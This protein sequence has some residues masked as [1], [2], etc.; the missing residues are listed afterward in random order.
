MTNSGKKLTIPTIIT[1]GLATFSMYFGGSC[2]L[3]PVTWG[4][5]SGSS[6]LAAMPGIIITALLLPYAAYIAMVRGGDSFWG[7][8]SG[9]GRRFGAVFGIMIVAVLGPLYSIP[10][11]S[12]AAWES[13]CKV[14]NITTDSIIPV[15]LFQIVFYAIGYW[16]LFQPASLMDKL[17]KI[18]T[19]VLLITVIAVVVKGLTNPLSDWV[20]KMYTESA[21]EYGL[22]S[23][24][25]TT[26]LPASL[27]FGIVI[28][29]NLKAKGV[30]KK[31]MMKPIVVIAG[32]G[33]ALLACTHLSQ[34]LLGA[35]TGDL[36][37]DYSYATLYA[38][39]ILAM[40]GKVGGIFF[41]IALMFAALTTVVGLAG[42]AAGFVGEV[43]DD[44]VPYR[45]C[46]VV[47]LVISMIISCFSLNT[48]VSLATPV[49]S[50]I[51]PPCIAMVIGYII[52][53][54]NHMTIIK[55]MTYVAFAWGIV[56][57][58]IGY[59]GLAGA[60][61]GSFMD[62]YNMVPLASNGL[63]WIIPTVLG[64]IVGFVIERGSK[65]NKAVQGIS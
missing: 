15:I 62:L 4:Q 20:P 37:K 29:T 2:M 33:F 60:D 3:W 54:R 44:K 50:L 40:W 16:F 5:Q 27:M 38:T 39:A 12:T 64:G 11:M 30:E 45:K 34:M 31:D 41:N 47:I 57:M 23:G 21:F 10:R 24:Y 48:I 36:F 53:A 18:L 65:S 25:Q 46:I 22:L 14:F 55:S 59:I 58:I 8:T 51:Y 13:L 42:G 32:I 56:D 7:M 63:G 19:P 28:I 52:F 43:S 61:A 1:F 6:V 17:G 49:I 9:L 35:S 26:D